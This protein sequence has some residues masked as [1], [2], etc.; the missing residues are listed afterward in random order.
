MT[1]HIFIY[2]CTCIFLYV[3]IYTPVYNVSI[4]IFTCNHNNFV[5]NH[6][7]TWKIEK[8]KKKLW[9]SFLTSPVR[10]TFSRCQQGK[11]ED[12]RKTWSYEPKDFP[13]HRQGRIFVVPHAMR[14]VG[15]IY[16]SK[17]WCLYKDFFWERKKRKIK[18]TRANVIWNE[19]W[20]VVICV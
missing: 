7:Y 16:V 19:Y 2:V 20:K 6:L 4:Y 12:H 5:F 14:R 15:G 17:F 10:S 18:M 11:G 1:R 13:D 9:E 3:Y 8:K